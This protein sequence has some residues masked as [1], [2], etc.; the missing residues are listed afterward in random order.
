MNTRK[1]KSKFKKIRIILEGGCSSTILIVRLIE[2]LA[3]EEDSPMQW[4]TQAKNITT[5]LNV[6]VDFTL[7]ALSTTNVVTWRF[8]VDDSAKGIYDVILGRH[9]LI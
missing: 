1:G 7:P 9:I 4:N 6:K 8:H 2:K 5:N 3:P